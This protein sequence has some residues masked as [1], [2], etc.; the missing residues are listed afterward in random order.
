M[1]S[2][3]AQRVKYEL[4]DTLDTSKLFGSPTFP[5]HFM[6]RKRLQQDY[7]F[8]QLNLEQLA[9]YNRVL[10]RTGMLYFF[11]H[12]GPKG[13]RPK[14]LYSDEPLYEVMD[15]VNEA[16]GENNFA[17]AL[18]LRFGEEAEREDGYV[19]GPFDQEV[20]EADRDDYMVLL[21]VDPL[22]MGI[23]DFPVFESPDD[24]IYFVLDEEDLTKGRFD[25]V[26]WV[27]HNS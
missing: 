8:A 14:V 19:L 13:I 15:G 24:E 23:A 10:P 5:A 3:A 27:T 22:E 9:P 2:F 1:I 6:R 12:F 20:P 16:F 11:L 7:F 17:D 25:R 21:K 18:H 4:N 26:K